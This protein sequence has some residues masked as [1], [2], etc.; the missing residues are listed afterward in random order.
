[1]L[2]QAQS[3]TQWSQE[4][5][6]TGKALNN[7]L[8]F[9]LGGFYF[10]AKGL[11]TGRIDLNYAGIDFLHGPDPTPATNKA[12]F[13]NASWKPFEAFTLTGGLRR[14]GP[15]GIWLCP[16]QSRWL[17]DPALHRLSVRREP[18]AQL[19]LAALNGLYKTFDA[20][21]LDW[22]VAADY[23]F[24]PALMV[25]GQVSTGYRSGRVNPRPFYP[26]QV[27]DFRP[28]TIT[29][30]EAGFKS[31][32]FDRRVRFNV[33]AFFNDYKNIIL[34]VLNCPN[35]AGFPTTPCLQPKNVGSAH[36]KG[37]EVETTIRPIEHLTLDGSLSW[38]KFKY[39]T[40]DTANTGVTA[41][42]V[43]PYTPEWKWNAG[44]SYD[45]PDV[46]KGWS[47]C[48]SMAATSRT[49]MSIPPTSTRSMFRPPRPARWPIKPRPT[50]STTISSPTPA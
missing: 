22:R 9:V 36:V 16:P 35:T 8:D 44:L 38:L 26:S 25:Y 17:H 27:E 40:V 24:S 37:I 23:R 30:Y 50:A 3:N 20:S 2:N 48:A 18:A 11:F 1:M 29:A 28:E 45:I 14:L 32:L 10:H 21:R 49:S 39:T 31:D 46:L 7:T 4:L 43:P 15:Q 5:R 42:M 41:S 13:A 19:R 34:T 6:L 47:R 12:I 33:S